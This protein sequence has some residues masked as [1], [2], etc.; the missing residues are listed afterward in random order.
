M[1]DFPDTEDPIE[2][3][4]QT[5][6][7]LPLA[8]TGR[9]AVWVDSKWPEAS[10]YHLRHPHNDISFPAIEYINDEWYYLN[11]NRGKYYTGPL[12]L[13]T[14]PIS[15]GLGTTDAPSVAAVLLPREPEV[16][17]S[18]SESVKKEES[19]LEDEDEPVLAQDQLEEGEELAAIFEEKVKISKAGHENVFTFGF[20][21]SYVPTMATTTWQEA[22]TIK[23]VAQ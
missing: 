20:D 23:G 13:I 18:V 6:A 19:S 7:D 21:A 15:L 14:M 8:L 3:V 22:A 12:S 4:P 10:T 1:V 11:W 16:A 5:R 17:S 2:V 9:A